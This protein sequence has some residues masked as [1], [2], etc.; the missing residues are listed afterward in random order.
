MI[1]LAEAMSLIKMHEASLK[2][3]NDIAFSDMTIRRPDIEFAPDETSYFDS[4]RWVIHI[5]IL[6]ILQVFRPETEEELLNAVQ[7]IMGHEEQHCRSTAS[8]PYEFGIQRGA[9]IL[10]EYISAKEEKSKR[11]F[12]TAKDYEYF[13]NSILPSMGIYISWNQLIDYIGGISNSVEDGRIE[14][15]RASRYPGYEELRLIHRGKFWDREGNF[16]PYDDIK[17]NAAEKLRVITN[18]ILCLATCQV[19]EMGYAKAYIDTPLYDEVCSLMP[20]IG[21]GVLASRTREMSENCIEISRK[22]APLFYEAC[23]LASADAAARKALEKMLADAI[24]AAVDHMPASGGFSLSEQDE[25]TDNDPNPMSAFPKSDLVITLDD[26]TF[27]KLEKN[28]KKSKAGGG[29]MV[30]REHPKEEEKKDDSKNGGPCKDGSGEGTDGA[31]DKSSKGSSNGGSK[32]STDKSKD[33]SGKASGG[34][35]EKEGNKEKEGEGAVSGSSGNEKPDG[36]D[37]KSGSCSGAEENAEEKDPKNASGQSGKQEQQSSSASSQNGSEGEQ[38][39]NPTGSSDS[40]DGQDSSSQSTPPQDQEGGLS[41]KGKNSDMSTDNLDVEAIRK[42]MKEASESA[43][44]RAKQDI[45]SVNSARAH[46]QKMKREEVIDTDAPI[47]AED[48]KGI[49]PDFVELKR[50]YKVKDNLP[51]VIAARGKTLFRKNQMYFKS[52]STPNVSFLDSG[53]VDPSR[54]YGLSFGDTEIFRKKGKDKKFDGCAY[55]LI[56]NSGSMS[57][58]KRIEACKAAAVIEESFRGLIPIKIV[59]FDYDWGVVHEVVKGWNE[60]LQKNCCWNFCL[61]GREGGGNADGYD[62]KIATKELLARPERKKLLMVLS[63]G[64]PTEA[65]SGFTKGAIDEARR[66]GIQVNGIYFEEGAIGRDAGQFRKMY[67][68]DYIICQAEELVEHVSKAMKR[69]SRS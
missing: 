42:A 25:D 35:E 9:E 33:K 53:S 2:L 8:K 69:F 63:D 31:K 65:T 48:V 37:Q 67:T 32:D 56:D 55:I 23:K 44:E 59:A 3:Q 43:R 50:N 29:L 15:I 20:Y 51:P 68:K 30:R 4:K 66:N 54:I 7:Y 38:D 17:E 21:K 6:G 12:R 11:R 27:D 47:T 18:Q 64:M 52:L 49:C 61:Y 39:G 57:G 19:Y 62:I 10:L 16:A 60:S 5:G 13:A 28:S 1:N 36:K 58:N 26:E 45:E 41:G 24:K 46:E 22:L 34:S 40:R 14:R